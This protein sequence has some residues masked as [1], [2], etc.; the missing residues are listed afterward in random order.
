MPAIAKSLPEYLTLID[1]GEG[2][3][4]PDRLDDEREGEPEFWGYALVG[5]IPT[6]VFCER[7]Y[8]QG[9]E[10]QGV[11]SF[12]WYSTTVDIFAGDCAVDC[13][14]CGRECTPWDLHYDFVERED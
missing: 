8:K 13:D 2:E 6:R 1:N 4:K 11:V 7:C 3:Y 9:V 12:V 5:L 10:T 14:K